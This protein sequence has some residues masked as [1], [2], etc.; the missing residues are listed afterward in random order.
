[1]SSVTVRPWAVLPSGLLHTGHVQPSQSSL[2]TAHLARGAGN[3]LWGSLSRQVIGS[4]MR[5]RRRRSAENEM[6][7]PRSYAWKTAL[8][9][10]LVLGVV[11]S[12]ATAA[13]EKN[14]LGEA[15]VAKACR[16]GTPDYTDASTRLA[17]LEAQIE[18]L[19]LAADHG[20][21][22]AALAALFRHREMLA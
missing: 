21:A 20:P 14:A 8:A 10:G 6:S 11:C 17:A 7:S 3:F 9:M 13:A 1:M 18:A 22:D 4:G 2:I 16:L 12:P 15:W 5:R 19:G